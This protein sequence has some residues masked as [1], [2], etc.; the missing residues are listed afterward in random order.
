MMSGDVMRSRQTLPNLGI[1]AIEHEGRV[2]E[3]IAT[4]VARFRCVVPLSCS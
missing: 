3:G 4:V 2:K 1:S